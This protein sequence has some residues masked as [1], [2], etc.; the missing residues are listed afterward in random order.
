[1]AI[2][3]DFIFPWFKFELAMKRN[4]SFHNYIC[5]FMKQRCIENIEYFITSWALVLCASD[6]ILTHQ[7][8]MTTISML[9]L[10]YKILIF[11]IKMYFL[12]SHSI[13]FKTKWLPVCRWHFQIDF[14]QCKLLYFALCLIERPVDNEPAL[15][16]IMAWHR[17]S[18]A[19]WYIY[20]RQ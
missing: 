7:Y 9:K 5:T 1:M 16:Q 19:Y 8:Y 4:N 13:E 20:M 17:T 15:V 11:L 6:T 18:M 14:L 12:T 10:A 3:R 2:H